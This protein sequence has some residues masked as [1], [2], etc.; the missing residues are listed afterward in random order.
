MG[1]GDPHRPA[2]GRHCCTRWS[3][4]YFWPVEYLCYYYMS[5]NH[6]LNSTESDERRCDIRQPL[7]EGYG[8]NIPDVP[9]KA[10]R[11]IGGSAI[12]KTRQL[13]LESPSRARISPRRSSLDSSVPK[14]PRLFNFAPAGTQQ[15]DPFQASYFGSGSSRRHHS[16]SRP[17]SQSRQPARTV[18]SFPTPDDSQT[19][20]PLPA[21]DDEIE[22]GQIVE[23]LVPHNPLAVVVHQPPTNPQ[24]TIADHPHVPGPSPNKSLSSDVDMDAGDTPTFSGFPT[25]AEFKAQ[26]P[27]AQEE[28]PHKNLPAFQP[29]GPDESLATP[30]IQ[31]NTGDWVGAVMAYAKL[32]ENM[33]DKAV[34]G[35][36]EN[37]DLHV[38]A[39]PF[40]GGT[41]FHKTYTAAPADL[42]KALTSVTG[43][44]A[45]IVAA[46]TPKD[47]K[48]GPPGDKYTSPGTMIVRVATVEMRKRLERYP[49]VPLTKSL[50]VRLYSVAQAKA[51]R[52]WCMALLQCNVPGD[53]AEVG[54]A[55]RW[56]IASAL[57]TTA[58]LRELIVRATQPGA[59]KIADAR[60]LDVARTISVRYVA[61]DQSPFW[62][63]YMKP[64]TSD[65]ALWE[66]IHTY[67][68]NM[69]VEDGI[70]SFKP[71]SPQPRGGAARP[72]WLCHLCKCDDHLAYCCPFCI[73]LDWWGPSA[74]ITAKTEG[75]LALPKKKAPPQNTRGAR[76]G[77]GGRS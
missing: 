13:L 74:L 26:L 35:I 65:Y 68:R 60:I 16:H 21:S 27:T 48:F 57:W 7:S 52:S 14:P 71:L 69:S 5:N 9:N 42:R 64:C 37:P 17:H 44:G 67:V 38:L 6:S 28:N 53:D 72:P 8:Q 47:P 77:R 3:R 31:T 50:A 63:V 40:L 22:E 11:G 45:L 75:E 73:A 49:L 41:Y 19:V 61:H 66:E 58:G 2:T 62:T 23:K 1:S 54:D 20:G 51:M 56:G 18:S 36:E 12:E 29:S 46:P 24:R 10:R 76:G 15:D 33:S 32:I 43:P 59:T 55:L 70:F 4:M 30:H 39:V 25:A 34:A